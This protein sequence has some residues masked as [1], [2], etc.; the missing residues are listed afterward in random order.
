MGQ[1]RSLKP[2]PKIARYGS[3][4][5][6]C[7]QP[8]YIETLIIKALT[9]LNYGKGSTR[10]C[11]NQY[12]KTKYPGTKR[13]DIAR[14]IR[15]GVENGVLEQP[16]GP[17]GLIRIVDLSPTSVSGMRSNRA[18]LERQG[19]LRRYGAVKPSNHNVSR[20]LKSRQK[21]AEGTTCV[22]K[23]NGS[24]GKSLKDYIVNQYFK[25]KN[26]LE[27]TITKVIE[28]GV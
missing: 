3:R 24:N 21:Q 10:Y 6:F 26:A 8:N 5:I 14:A 11:V 12:I 9:R 23:R 28:D 27:D 2:T 4:R 25:G 13:S 22:N 19:M 1:T 7:L 18:N 15:E 20:R 17:N 16:N